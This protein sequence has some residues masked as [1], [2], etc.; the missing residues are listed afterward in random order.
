[1]SN[2]LDG[3]VVLVTGASSG[4]G[5]ATALALSKAGARVA[6]GAR[7][8]DRLKSLAQDA[9]GEILVLELDVTDR[10]SVQDAVTAAVEHFGALDALVNNAG[11]MLSGPILNADTAE[12]TRMIDTNLLGSMY[13]AHAAL[14]HLLE[15]RGAVVQ[16]SS[17]AGRT[18]PAGGGVYAA[19]KFGITAFSEALR[20]KV[21]AQ[22]VRVIVIEP[23]MVATEL[24]THITDPAMQA[25]A[26]SYADSMRT[27]QSPDIADAVLYALTQPEHVA[28]NEILIRPTDQTR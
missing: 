15:S 10:E 28:V 27:L 4:I 7:R 16:I 23:G 22:G 25:L 17:T 14:P 9:P 13:T 1:M 2:T 6:V 21:T 20:Q 11:V 19:T 12:W 3:K 5:Q 8:A 26:K 18:A 24:A